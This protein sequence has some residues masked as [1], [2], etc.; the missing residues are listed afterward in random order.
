MKCGKL[1]N[2]LSW[3]TNYSHRLR[4]VSLYAHRALRLSI[5]KSG[6]AL[7]IPTAKK[8]PKSHSMPVSLHWQMFMTR[9]GQN[10]VIKQPGIA[11]KHGITLLNR[12]DPISI[13]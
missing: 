10:G 9:F 4:E 2:I 3:G 1:C 6:T 7:D 5:T 8:Q 11:S 13:L 12:Q